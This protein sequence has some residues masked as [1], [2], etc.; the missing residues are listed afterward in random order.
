M[1]PWHP[2]PS[3]RAVRI[4][5]IALVL[6]LGLAFAAAYF[7][8][9]TDL[10]SLLPPDG[11]APDFSA[12]QRQDLHRTF[13]TIWAALGL[14]APA[15]AFFVVR[16]E[17]ALL[18]SL[19]RAFW[20]ASLLAFAVHFYWAVVVMFGNDWGRIL[21]TSRVSA[22]RLDTVFAVWWCVDVALAWLYKGEPLWVR[23]QR[24]LVHALAFL[25]FFMGAAREGE[26]LASRVLGW[27][28]AALVVAAFGWKLWLRRARAQARAQA[29]PPAR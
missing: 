5:G 18:G 3:S 16:R 20:T 9:Q 21:H 6:L 12:A 17:S 14:A 8:R 19:W 23:V 27:S 29:P 2:A 1:T 28:F 13:F 22:P 25:L 4:A 15:L 24:W 7:T 11:A 10:F 26:L